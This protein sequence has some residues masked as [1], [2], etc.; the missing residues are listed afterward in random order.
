M[1]NFT[2]LRARLNAVR[3]Q[4]VDRKE[5][6]SAVAESLRQAVIKYHGFPHDS[7]SWGS[8]IGGNFQ[9]DEIPRTSRRT[10]SVDLVLAVRFEI[11]PSEPIELRHF[12][13]FSV[14]RERQA[15]RPVSDN[16]FGR[17]TG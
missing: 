12:I 3:G 15:A 4:E 11:G 9:K 8:M 10:A 5:Q 13:P 6:L 16:Y 7:I 2:E 17:S 14:R 1:G